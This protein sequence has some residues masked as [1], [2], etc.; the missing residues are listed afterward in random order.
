MSSTITLADL[1]LFLTDLFE[2]READ[3]LSSEAGAY[4]G[5]QLRRRQDEI[6]ALP[7]ALTERSPFAEELARADGRHDG[8]GGAIFHATEAVLRLPTA[9]AAVVAAARNVREA[10]IPSLG[11]LGGSYRAE[12][13]RALERGPLL[14]SMADD[15]RSLT[16]A[17][18]PT[19]LEVAT[20]FLAEGRQIHELL[21]QRGDV[22]KAA[23]ARAAAL[24]SE[25]IGV[26]NRLRDDLGRELKRRAELPRDLDQKVFGYLD[27]LASMQP[28]PSA[29]SGGGE[30]TPTA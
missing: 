19:L 29:P 11:Q 9:S 1:R 20:S 3:L 21:S 14:A 15:L 18:G 22:P 12:A 30:A 23:R 27:T 7:R 24:R 26:V 13:D 6:A 4:Y 17:G 25:T 10:F 28:A 16:I 2:K 5:P 8:H